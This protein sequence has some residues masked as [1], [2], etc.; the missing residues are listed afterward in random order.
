MATVHQERLEQAFLNLQNF[1]E[2]KSNLDTLFRDLIQNG[3]DEL[4]A[5]VHAYPLAH[6][7]GLDPQ[8]VTTWLLYASHIGLFDLNW[9]SHCPR[10]KGLDTV[11]AHVGSIRQDLS[12][13]SCQHAFHVHFDEDIE[14]TFSLNGTIRALKPQYSVYIPP[15][16]IVLGKYTTAQPIPLTISKAAIYFVFK[17]DVDHP[18]YFLEVDPTLPPD[19]TV[20]LE[21]PTFDGPPQR[22]KIGTGT[23]QLTVT[24][25][26]EIGFGYVDPQIREAFMPVRGLEVTMLPVYQRLY[27]KQTLSQRESLSIRNLT[28]LFTDITGSTA[29]YQRL[30]DIKAY[31]LVRDHFEVLF[32]EIEA[33]GGIVVKT[34]GDAVMAAFASPEAALQAGLAVQAAIRQFNVGRQPEDGLILVKIGMHMGSV[35][36]VNLNDHLDYFGNMVNLAARVQ[37]QSRSGEILISQQVYQDAAVQHLLK[38]SN[39]LRVTESMFE[40]AGID[41]TQRLFSVAHSAQWG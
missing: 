14:V 12:C 26:D 38:T 27:S 17:P 25:V 6:Q 13:R 34:I 1:P 21:Y 36:A 29:L 41:E 18:F 10:C 37:G 35:I 32:Q 33:L 20:A 11:S 30:G 19:S 39:D 9:E 5:R 2:R 24:G 7:W 8:Q 22:V 4:L 40:L 15:G 28:I 3:T 31:N 16:A 23:L